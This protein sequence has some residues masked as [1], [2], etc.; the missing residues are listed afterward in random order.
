MISNRMREFRQILGLQTFKEWQLQLPIP[1]RPT[2]HYLSNKASWTKTTGAIQK[3]PFH[4]HHYSLIQ[5]ISSKRQPLDSQAVKDK[6][7]IC[8]KYNLRVL[9]SKRSKESGQKL[10][11]KEIIRDTNISKMSMT[12]NLRHNLLRLLNKRIQL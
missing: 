11:P 4:H 6:N 5:R 9:V 10:I 1:Q 8:P 2:V 7:R 3:L 12:M